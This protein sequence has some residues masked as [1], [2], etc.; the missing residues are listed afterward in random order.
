MQVVITGKQLNESDPLRGHVESSEAKT[1]VGSASE[2]STK[3]LQ[4]SKFYLRTHRKAG[5]ETAAVQTQQYVLATEDDHEDEQ[6]TEVGQPFV[7]AKRITVID[8]LTGGGTA[9]RM[10]LARC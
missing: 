10:V 6:T 4:R 9:T 2:G 7:I 3:M 1:P 5:P 8:K